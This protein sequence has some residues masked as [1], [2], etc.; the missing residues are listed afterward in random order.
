MSVDPNR[1]AGKQLDA[2]TALHYFDARYYRQTWGRFTSVDPLH[3]GA[4]MTDPQQWNRYAYARNN[5][6]KW[7]DAT[8]LQMTC[9]QYGCGGIEETVGV[10]VTL[11]DNGWECWDAGQPCTWVDFET[12]DW[13]LPGAPNNG[14]MPE[15][16][17]GGGGTAPSSGSTGTTDGGKNDMSEEIQAPKAPKGPFGPFGT[18][19]Q[20]TALKSGL[21]DLKGRINEIRPCGKLFGGAGYATSVLD[22]T[23]YRFI[24]LPQNPGAAAGVMGPRHIAIVPDGAFMRG[25]R[26]GFLGVDW[27]LTS[28]RS[29]ILGHELGHQVGE[30]GKDPNSSLNQMH[31]QAVIDSCGF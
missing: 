8:G 31:T 30:F 29:L 7:M 5:P 2:E 23:T 27:D 24:P 13:M 11:T 20:K 14:T 10:S 12:F 4:A 6:F 1:F 3:V 19:E 25:I 22:S 26:R 17:G 16:Q 18:K 28:S 9:T 15:D 21:N